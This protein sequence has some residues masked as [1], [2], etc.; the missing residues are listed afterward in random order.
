[1]IVGWV[2]LVNKINKKFPPLI[3]NDKKRPDITFNAALNCPF[4]GVWQ[5]LKVEAIEHECCDMR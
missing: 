5:K 1:M 4:I 3:K 2:R